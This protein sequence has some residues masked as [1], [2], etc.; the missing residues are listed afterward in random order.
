MYIFLPET[1]AKRTRKEQLFI[2]L[3]EVLDPDDAELLIAMKDRKM[4]YENITEDLVRK[5]FPDLLPPRPF[6]AESPAETTEI[7][8]VA[9]V[10]VP[11]G[12]KPPKAN[13]TNQAKVA[14]WYTRQ[15][16]IEANRK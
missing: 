15:A 9:T 11:H 5:T 2:E 4:P 7:K 3:L 8:K 16:E 14:A 6:Q 1:N 10:S 12:S 13:S